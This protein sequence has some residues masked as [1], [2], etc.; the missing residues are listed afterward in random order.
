[1]QHTLIEDTLCARKYS[2]YWDIVKTSIVMDLNIDGERN[3][4]K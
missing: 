3:K 4:N 2:R 1:M